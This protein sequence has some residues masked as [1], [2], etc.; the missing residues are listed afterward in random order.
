MEQN[1]RWGEQSHIACLDIGS[2][3][4][5]FPPLSSCLYFFFYHCMHSYFCPRLCTLGHLFVTPLPNIFYVVGFKGLFPSPKVY[6]RI[7]CHF[8]IGG[9]LTA[10]PPIYPD[11]VTWCC[12]AGSCPANRYNLEVAAVLVRF[13]DRW[14]IPQSYPCL[15]ESDGI[16]WPLTPILWDIF[17]FTVSL[18]R[19]TAEYAKVV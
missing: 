3:F 6:G 1:W 13:W 12:S 17:F 4:I 2:F 18:C 16:C 5:A 11:N 10:G 7:S 8:P 9:D 15:L 14:R 19:S